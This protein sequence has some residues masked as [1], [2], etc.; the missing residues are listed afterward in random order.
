MPDP[1]VTDGR[2][3][4]SIAS[5]CCLVESARTEATSAAM[6]PFPALPKRPDSRTRHDQQCDADR[7]D[8]GRNEPN[9]HHVRPLL[10]FRREFAMLQGMQCH[11]LCTS[12]RFAPPFSPVPGLCVAQYRG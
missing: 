11:D 7:H 1:T 9:L 10:G 2:G 4:W 3:P 5:T 12:P 8:T 6:V